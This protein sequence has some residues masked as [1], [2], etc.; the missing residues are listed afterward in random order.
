M[1]D[2]TKATRRASELR[3]ALASIDDT[4]ARLTLLRFCGDVSKVSH[5]LRLG[6][7]LQ[8]GSAAVAHDDELRRAV[9]DCLEGPIADHCWRQATL[10]VH[11]GGLGIRQAALVGLIAFVASAVA[12][13]PLIADVDASMAQILPAGAVIGAVQRRVNEAVDRMLEP[14]PAEVRAEMPE[15][16][17][18]TRQF[19][20]A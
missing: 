4:A 13:E 7:D 9:E 16:V 3:S 12:A 15:L 14:H 20:A 10:G 17:G 6:G 2:L 5:A 18:S 1:D 19:V 8:D 11:E